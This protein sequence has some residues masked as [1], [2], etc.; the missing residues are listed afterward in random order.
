MEDEANFAFEPVLVHRDLGCEHVLYDPLLGSISGIIDWE[1]AAVGDPA[2]DFA[3]LIRGL[4]RD[5]AGRVAKHYKGAVDGSFWNR[6]FFYSRTGPYSE[7]RYGIETGQRAH[8]ESGLH[9]IN[10]GLA[11]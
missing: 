10:Q 8:F 4:G 2:I 9:R 7:I 6:A 1:A 5:F 3:G 11:G